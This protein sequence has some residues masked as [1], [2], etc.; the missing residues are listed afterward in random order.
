M[1]NRYEKMVKAIMYGVLGIFALM[2]LYPLFFVLIT[3]LKSPAEYVSNKLLM[4][5][6]PTFGNFYHVWVKGNMLRYFLNSCILIPSGLVVYLFVCITAGFAFGR[7][8]FPHRFPLFLAVLFL[9][10]FPQM[11]LSIQIF[12]ICRKLHLV[13]SYLGLILVWV[14]YF[15]PFGTYIMTTYYATVP[16]EIVE[17]ARLDGTGVYRMLYYIM[18]PIAKPMIIIIV[19]IGTQ[20]MWNELPFSLLLLQ[21]EQLRTITQ[22]LGMLQGQYGLDDTTLSASILSA[23]LVPLLLFVFFQR[24]ITMGSYSGA[25]KG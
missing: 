25:V 4:P 19:V 12:Q 11:L 22:G 20:S 7:L 15:G 14:A 8:R 5:Q 21:T 24:Q 13:N 6:S 23:S 2:A 18:V 16:M 1:S 17:S 3:S 10:I 9:M